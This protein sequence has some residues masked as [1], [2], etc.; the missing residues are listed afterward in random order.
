VKNEKKNT[1]IEVPDVLGGMRLS[2]YK[3]IR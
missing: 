1:E 2:M 3:N